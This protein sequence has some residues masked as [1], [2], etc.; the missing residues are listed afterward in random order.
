MK[1]QERPPKLYM[2]APHNCSYILGQTASTLMLEPD[3]PL[4]D[5]QFAV[6]LKSGYRRSGDIV[7]KPH[8][9]ACNACISVR[10][11]VWEFV[12]SRAQKRCYRRNRDVHNEILSPCF[13]KEHFD[14]FC[15]YQSWRHSGDAL[16]HNNSVRYRQFMIDSMVKT[17]FM[18]F[19]IDNE[20]VAM[21]VC[22]LPHRGISAVYTIFD[23]DREKRGLGTFAIMK[24]IEYA[25]E[26]NLDYVYLGYWIK[27]CHKM[28]YKTRF[29]PLEG[30]ID[31]EWQVLTEQKIFRS[32]QNQ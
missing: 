9:H 1:L 17:L 23:P 7:Y 30:F 22:D 6:L 12:P 14:L 11:P 28:N 8:C 19:R 18:E 32:K 13:R 5:D 15:R 20:L 24:Q 31:K 2:S 21:S 26:Y 27:Q 4:N 3:Y 29:K 25:K 16:D 10:I